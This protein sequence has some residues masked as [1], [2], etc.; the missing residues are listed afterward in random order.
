MDIKTIIR[1]LDLMQPQLSEQ[2]Y[3]NMQRIL[4]KEYLMDEIQV[5]EE[6]LSRKVKKADIAHQFEQELPKL[7]QQLAALD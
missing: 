4:R 5:R 6:Y 7:Q 2:D 3:L 1:V